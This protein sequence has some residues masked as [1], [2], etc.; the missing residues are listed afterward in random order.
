M[1]D[2]SDEWVAEI[3]KSGFANCEQS[4]SLAIEV[5]CHRKAVAAEAARIKEVVSDAAFG[6]L[7]TNMAVEHQ[8]L[9]AEA[10]GDLAADQ[11][12]TAWGPGMLADPVRIAMLEKQ[13]AERPQLSPDDLQIVDLALGYWDSDDNDSPHERI[14]TIREAI[15]RPRG[16]R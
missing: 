7:P 12:A 6:L 2:L 13:L 9:T 15:R 5:Q 1:A 16:I 4:E 10:I 8:T 3:A 11:L 14:A